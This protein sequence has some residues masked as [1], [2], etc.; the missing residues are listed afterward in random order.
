L[1]GSVTV[2]VVVVMLI[3]VAVVVVVAAAAVILLKC[4]VPFVESFSVIEVL[5]GMRIL[6]S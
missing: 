4:L 5:F 3:M 6:V 1:M 2:V